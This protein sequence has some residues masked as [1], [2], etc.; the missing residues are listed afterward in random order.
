MYVK[1][2]LLLWIKN[3]SVPEHVGVHCLEGNA[4]D[5]ALDIEVGQGLLDGQ[6]VLALFLAH[7]WPN[8]VIYG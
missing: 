6:D 8:F 5:L 1:A 2:C 4:P 3:L 7:L